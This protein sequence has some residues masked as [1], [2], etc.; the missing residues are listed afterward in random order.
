MLLCGG[1]HCVLCTQLI[2]L[3]PRWSCHLLLVLPMLLPPL[4]E[5][6]LDHIPAVLMRRCYSGSLKKIIEL[7]TSTLESLLMVLCVLLFT[8]HNDDT[9]C[10]RVN[11]V[12]A[13]KIRLKLLL[14]TMAIPMKH[15]SLYF[16]EIAF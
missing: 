2:K 10:E 4:L 6:A 14:M 12:A 8:E 15:L 5:L 11:W 16:Y 3:A 13:S 1:D 7:R 9:R